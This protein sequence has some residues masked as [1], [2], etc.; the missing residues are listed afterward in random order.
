[1]KRT[2]GKAGGRAPPRKRFRPGKLTDLPGFGELRPPKRRLPTNFADIFDSSSV[3]DHSVKG[4][5]ADPPWPYTRCP[6]IRSRAVHHYPTMTMKEICA[7]PIK[8]I[9]HKACILIMWVTGPHLLHAGEV[10]KAWGFRYVGFFQHW[11]KTNTHSL[12][13]MT[14]G[15]GKYVRSSAHEL[16]I[17]AQ[18]GEAAEEAAPATAAATAAAAAPAGGVRVSYSPAFYTINDHVL[19]D[20]SKLALLFRKGTI[21]SAYVTKDRSNV[22]TSVLHAAADLAA[23]QPPLRRLKMHDSVLLSPRGR[24]SAKP[25]EFYE[26][27]FRVFTGTAQR[28]WIELF[29]RETYQNMRCWGNEF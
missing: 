17:M 28:D 9:A 22:P 18:A 5:I 7:L 27:L 19:L 15:I 29:A 6:G 10:C 12:A 1:M 4:I 25:R 8:R 23:T 14:N 2:R 13:L 20:D 3:P 21:H 24:H 11:H 16:V 26:R